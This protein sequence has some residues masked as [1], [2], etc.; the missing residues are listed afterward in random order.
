MGDLGVEG[1]LRPPSDWQEPAA[2]MATCS[3]EAPVAEEILLPV[4]GLM[5][6]LMALLRDEDP[7]VVWWIERPPEMALTQGVHM[8]PRSR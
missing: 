2:H 7:R 8:V 3:S 5:E 6:T 4:F 1:P